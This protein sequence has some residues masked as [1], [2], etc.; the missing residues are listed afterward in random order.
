MLSV[1]KNV[2]ARPIQYTLVGVIDETADLEK[3]L[4]IS[5]PS[6]HLYCRE[7]SRI[8]S[9][10]IK[11]WRDYIGTLRKQNVS[12][13]FFE[14][15]PPLM[16]TVNYLSD[17]INNDEIASFCAPF[18]CEKCGQLDLKIVKM[19]EAVSFAATL[20]VVLCSKCQNKTVFDGIQE[21]YFSF[22]LA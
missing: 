5:Q 11:L 10:G 18:L 17:F 4:A 1:A 13:R 9:V 8:N 15:S 14:L 7:V 21:E 6:A 16:A 19:E 12:L 22:L 20:P 2:L 3:S